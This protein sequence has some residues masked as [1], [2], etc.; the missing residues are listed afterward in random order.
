MPST[1]INR[2]SGM[3]A[4]VA[5]RSAAAIQPSFSPHNTECGCLISRHAPFQ[6]TALP[7]SRL[8]L[9]G[10]PSQNAFGRAECLLPAVESRHE[11][12]RKLRDDMLSGIGEERGIDR[13]AAIPAMASNPKAE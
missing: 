7:R 13:E 5:L 6:G 2:Q 4:A 9:K 12:V 3:A 1:G 8:R 10:V 11:Q